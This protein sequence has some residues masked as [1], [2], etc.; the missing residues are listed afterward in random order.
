MKCQLVSRVAAAASDVSLSLMLVVTAQVHTLTACI[1]ITTLLQQRQHSHLRDAL[2]TRFTS[3]APP[4]C[5]LDTVH[6][7]G[8]D[9]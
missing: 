4:H 8:Y 1:I 6:I 9:S 3:T 7:F 5:I 2:A